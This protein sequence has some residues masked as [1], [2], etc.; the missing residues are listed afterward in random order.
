METQ[1]PCGSELAPG[2]VPTKAAA[3]PTSSVQ[4][5]RYREQARFHIGFLM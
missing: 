3:N 4:I 5:H 2:G 1:D